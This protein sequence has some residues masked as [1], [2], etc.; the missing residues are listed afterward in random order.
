MSDESE[1]E[2]VSAESEPVFA[3]I[4][5][6]D[7]LI[8]GDRENAIRILNEE[9]DRVQSR[10]TRLLR[11]EQM[12]SG[13]R[14]RHA[15]WVGHWRNGLP[16]WRERC[17]ELTAAQ[18]RIAG[19][20]DHIKN[21][22]SEVEQLRA[23]KFKRFN[24]EDCWIYQGDGED[25][26][27]SLVCPVVVSPQKMIELETARHSL[28]GQIEFSAGVIDQQRDKN[29]E[30]EGLLQTHIRR[31]QELQEHNERLV[32]FAEQESKRVAE[33]EQLLTEADETLSRFDC[34]ESLEMH[35]KIRKAIKGK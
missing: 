16:D 18:Q 9:I 24:N 30:L 31:I 11:S 23:V 26:L 13:W 20:I 21:L 22:E 32:A 14:V 34:Q 19:H 27:E 15:L 5:L 12:P 29:A 35:M 28:A 8:Q 2:T 6:V 4:D 33:L 10:F 17:S 1:S 7:E 25:H 3:M